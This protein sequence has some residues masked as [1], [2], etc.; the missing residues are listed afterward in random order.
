MTTTQRQPTPASRKIRIERTFKASLEEV[1]ELWTTKEGIESW[2]G[3]DGFR[4][5]VRRLELRPGGR[6]EYAMIASS[7]EMVAFMKKEGMPGATETRATFAEVM[8]PRRLTLTNHMD[9]I[10]GV[11]PYDSTATV[12]LEATPDGV[13]LIVTLDPMHDETW[14]QRAVMGWES[15]LG[16]LAKVL[17]R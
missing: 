8:P 14:T 13:R 1:W 5:E 9:F 12:E 11:A 4:V 17:E 7:P 15:E 10:P 3:P 2:W 16:K 6:L